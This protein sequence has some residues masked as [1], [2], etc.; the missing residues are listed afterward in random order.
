MGDEIDCDILDGFLTSNSA[1]DLFNTLGNIIEDKLKGAKI[2]NLWNTR[3]SALKSTA[4]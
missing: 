3:I 2:Y 4:I 1:K